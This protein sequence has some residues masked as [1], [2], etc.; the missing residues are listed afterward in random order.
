M[1]FSGRAGRRSRRIAVSEPQP[2]KNRLL[3]IGRYP[4]TPESRGIR[5]L[6]QARS[7]LV[8]SLTR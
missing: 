6:F 1:V 7:P 3:L 8:G 4:L 5:K 2:V